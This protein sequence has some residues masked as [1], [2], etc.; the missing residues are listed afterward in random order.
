M[1]MRCKDT[2]CAGFTKATSVP[3]TYTPDTIKRYR[4]CA[5]CR[6]TFTSIE[7]WHDAYDGM[8]VCNGIEPST[9]AY[10]NLQ[11]FIEQRTHAAPTSVA[12]AQPITPSY[13]E[14]TLYERRAA[15]QETYGDDFNEA[16]FM[17]TAIQNGWAPAPPPAVAPEPIAPSH[18]DKPQ[19]CTGTGLYDCTCDVCQPG[20]YDDYE[21]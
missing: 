15:F 1:A 12:T 7:I 5:V 16:L 4:K 17:Q 18:P 11:P 20:L 19:G 8:L 3:A 6:R 2:N 10:S 9:E 21:G 14:P 13:T